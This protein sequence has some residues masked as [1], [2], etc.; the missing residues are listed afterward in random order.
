MTTSF[1]TATSFDEMMMLRA[2]RMHALSLLVINGQPVPKLDFIASIFI[3]D[4][5]YFNVFRRYNSTYE[6]VIED[7]YNDF[8]IHRD[9]SI[10]TSLQSVLC[11]TPEQMSN[12]KITEAISFKRNASVHLSPDARWSELQMMHHG[13]MIS[14]EGILT[15]YPHPADTP[16]TPPISVR[17]TVVPP[18]PRKDSSYHA[19]CGPC[20]DYIKTNLFP[21]AS[22]HKRKYEEI[23]EDEEDLEEE[24]QEVQEDQEEQ[25][26]QDGQDE[27]EEQDEQVEDQ[28]VQEEDQEVQEESEPEQKITRSYLCLRSRRIRRLHAR[29][30]K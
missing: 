1:A 11:L 19:V 25:E 13:A 12:M 2:E 5:H 24:D 15:D 3:Y 30:S 16:V 7:F 28:E 23:S 27:Q 29:I 10:R 22:D 20:I 4:T 26:E 18:A 14:V 8:H 21:C 9:H 17:G 6:I